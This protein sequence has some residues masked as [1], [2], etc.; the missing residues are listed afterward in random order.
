VHL[1]VSAQTFFIWE[2]L[3]KPSLLGAGIEISR[4]NVASNNFRAAQPIP[5]I[6][7]SNDATPQWNLVKKAKLLK[8]AFWGSYYKRLPKKEFPSQ[9]TPIYKFLKTQPIHT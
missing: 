9:N 8:F 7:N 6:S 5:V 2:L 1:G 3:S 4:L